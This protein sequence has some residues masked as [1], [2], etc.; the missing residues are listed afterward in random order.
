MSL[1]TR[2]EKIEKIS[3]P[4]ELNVILIKPQSDKPLP[5]PV[6]TGAVTIKYRHDE[7]K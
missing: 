1:K 4:D 6:K 2:L 5:D 3:N 7:N